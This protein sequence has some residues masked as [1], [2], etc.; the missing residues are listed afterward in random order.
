[1]VDPVFS[2]STSGPNAGGPA[3]EAIL[4]RIEGCVEAISHGFQRWDD[5][6]AR[7]PGFYFI[8]ARDS[9]AAFAAP[10]GTNRWPVE[11]RATVLGQTDVS[12][13]TALT[14]GFSCGCSSQVGRSGPSEKYTQHFRTP[15]ICD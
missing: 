8:V 12:R 15:R 13:G 6:H 4:A 1:M 10:M 14:V 9:M 11:D 2:D 3:I 7:G 5:P